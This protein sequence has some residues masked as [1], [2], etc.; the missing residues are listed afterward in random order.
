MVG[1]AIAA[2]AG[3]IAGALIGQ[4]ASAAARQQ[5]QAAVA[6]AVAAIEQV[7]AGPDLAREIYLQEFK[8]AGVLTPENEQYINQ[9]SSELA[10]VTGNAQ[11]QDAQM[12]A[13][14]SLQQRAQVGLSPEDR[15]RLA[16]IQDQVAQEAEGKRQQILQN[17]AARGMGG[18]GNE[19]LAALS[20]SQ[21]ATQRASQE[22]LGVA[23]LASQNALQALSQTGQLG[24]QIQSQSFNEASTRA[25]AADQ[26]NRFNIQNQLGV[27]SRN[28]ANQNQAQAANLQNAQNI[29]NM[30]VGQANSELNRQRQAEQQQYLNRYNHAVARSNAYGGQATALQNQ[31]NQQAQQW[32]N[33]GTGIGEGAGAFANYNAK[34]P[35]VEKPKVQMNNKPAYILPAVNKEFDPNKRES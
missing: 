20:G 27:Q 23:S 18:G 8:K 3:P 14:Q 4:Q 12:K 24:G 30:N 21:A 9:N 28:V 33:I 29:S 5:A 22:G 32:Q 13:L 11:A 7:G 16:Q 1:L 6:N 34:N 25:S 15:A 19:L 10:K 35:S 17:F 2:A 31:A 26:M